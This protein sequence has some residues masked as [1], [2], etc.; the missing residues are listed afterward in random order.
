MIKVLIVEDHEL[1]RMGLSM[2]LEQSSEMELSGEAENGT[3]GVELAKELSP[4]V[5]IMDI[6]LP[7][8]DGIEA[9]KQ[10]KSFNPNCKI[11]ICTSRDE[12]RDVFESFKSG[13]DGYIM[14]GA[15]KE[16]MYNAI[17]SV[18]EGAI[19]IDPAIARFVLSSLRNPNQIADDTSK[20]QSGE[21]NYEA[22]KQLY[23][24]T[25]REMQ[26]LSLIVEGMTNIQIAN[27][28]C[29]SQFTAKTHVHS[30]LQKLSAETRAKATNTALTEGLV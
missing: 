4:D 9:T 11:L 20:S 15:S 17:K 1:T 12:D 25:E 7:V 6:G 14:K 2:M 19:W 13:A 21:I 16:Q 23:G 8:I 3:K 28:L 5:I 22:G 30:V 29:I 26:V 27:E 18:N 24:L 10:I